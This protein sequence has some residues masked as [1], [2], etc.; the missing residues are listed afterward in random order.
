MGKSTPSAPAPDPNIGKAALKQAE[1]GEQWLNFASE[2]FK[3]STERQAEL[4]KLTASI[5]NRQIGL[6]EGQLDLAKQT[7]ADQRKL[8]EDQFAYTKEVTDE[9]RGIARE[10]AQ[11]A[12]EDRERYN[13]VFKP[14]EDAFV[15][16]ASNY[17][18]PERRAAAAAEAKS[19]VQTAA[20]EQR[21]A[22]QRE[23]ASMGVNPNSGRF[24]GLNRSADL[25]T[26]LASAGAQNN[27]RKEVEKTGLALKADVANLGRGLPAQSSN[28]AAMGLNANNAALSNSAAA[29]GLGMNALGAGAAGVGSAVGL[30]MN[31]L[32]ASLAAA[33]NNQG[34][35]NSSTGMMNAGFSGAM[36]GYG[37]MAGT[38]Q[39]QY[40]TQVGIWQTQQQ[41]AAQN[42]AGLGSA[43]G[44][45]VGLAFMSDEDAKEAKTEIPDGAALEAVKNMPVEEWSYK[46]GIA[47]EGR[48]VGTYAQDFQRETGK[49]DGKSIPAQDAIGI[50][51]KAVQDLDTKIEKIADAVGIGLG[52][53]PAPRKKLQSAPTSGRVPQKGARVPVELGLAA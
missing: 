16:Q 41:M 2:S 21:A 42:A 36:Q 51:M 25:G 23:A 50:T 17:D 5:S 18:T 3:I 6:A 45:I 30:N 40:N 14:V 11:Y 28:A 4:D 12:R 19:D 24:Q 32:G 27:A 44:G 9:Q 47:D 38:L 48:H 29:T 20:A 37:G 39:N 26:A 46:P 10:H 49:G 7:A 8:A 31:A 15:E 22:A 13:T 52:S 53:T 33:Q 34:L 35:Y 1:T 43:L